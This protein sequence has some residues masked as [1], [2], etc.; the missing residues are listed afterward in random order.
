MTA[1]PPTYIYVHEARHE[2]ASICKFTAETSFP[3]NAALVSL[4]N[5]TGVRRQYGEVQS[6][7]ASQWEIVSMKAAGSKPPQVDRPRRLS[8]R[9]W[10]DLF[11]QN[12]NDTGAFWHGGSPLGELDHHRAPTAVRQR[13]G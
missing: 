2:L 4:E 9:L 7:E 11:D 3:S 5:L 12:W 6:F 1:P 13:F 8:Y 10:S